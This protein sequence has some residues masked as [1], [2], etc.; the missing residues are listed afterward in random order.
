MSF[1]LLFGVAGRLVLSEE[2][3]VHRHDAPSVMLMTF[4]YFPYPPLLLKLR[5]IDRIAARPA[6]AAVQGIFDDERTECRVFVATKHIDEER[7]RLRMLTTS[8][9]AAKAT[10]SQGRSFACPAVQPVTLPASSRSSHRRAQPG[11]DIMRRSRPEFAYFFARASDE[12]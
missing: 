1:L 9:A 3:F 10:R 12:A 6:D 5:K 11:T 8:A 4:S 2:R 7:V